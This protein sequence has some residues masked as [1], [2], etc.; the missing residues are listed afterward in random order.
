[1]QG[2]L[3][4]WHVIAAK[5]FSLALAHPGSGIVAAA[6]LAVAGWFRLVR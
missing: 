2:A 1:M 6:V 3:C 5:G 4:G